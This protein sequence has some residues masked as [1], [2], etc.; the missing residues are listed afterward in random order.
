VFTIA[1]ALDPE[2]SKKLKELRKL[3][4]QAKQLIYKMDRIE[5]KWNETKNELIALGRSVPH[6]LG[7]VLSGWRKKG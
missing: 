6:R 3:E 2:I 1:V 4:Q 7:D 5:Q